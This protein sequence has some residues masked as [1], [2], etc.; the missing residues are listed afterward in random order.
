MRDR[1]ITFLG[2]LAAICLLLYWTWTLLRPTF[3]SVRDSGSGGIGA[4]SAGG[5]L[6]LPLTILGLALVGLW[7]VIR[8]IVHALLTGIR[9]RN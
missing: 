5:F 9:S 3:E 4:V 1:L 6:L 7:T 8:A 2:F